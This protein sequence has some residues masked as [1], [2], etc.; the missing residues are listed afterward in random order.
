MDNTVVLLSSINRNLGFVLDTIMNKGSNTEKE[1]KIVSDLHGTGLKSPASAKA[2]AGTPEDAGGNSKT[3]KKL[4]EVSIS[5][6][7]RLL[8]ELPA[9]VKAV[10]KIKKSDIKKFEYSMT[11]LVEVL[12]DVTKKFDNKKAKTIKATADLL[13]AMHGIGD[14]MKD[15]AKLPLIAPF[16]KLGAK[17]VG[18]IINTL[19][20][21][22]TKVAQFKNPKKLNKTITALHRCVIDVILLATT[23]VIMVGALALVGLIVK[24]SWDNILIG[25][26][27]VAVVLVAL[28]GITFLVNLIAKRIKMSADDFAVVMV[29]AAFGVGLV[30]ACA[31]LGLIVSK[32]WLFVLL[33]FTGI[34]LTLFGITLVTWGVAMIAKNF[35]KFAIDV[36]MVLGMF[37]LAGLI[38]AMSALLGVLI[39][40]RWAEVIYGFA[41]I[42]STLSLIVGTAW[43]LAKT[44]ADPAIKTAA[45]NV[46]W[47]EGAIAGAGALLWYCM[48]LGNAV[49][50]YFKSPGEAS[51]KLAGT[52]GLITAIIYGAFGISKLAEKIAPEAK[53]GAISLLI[54]EGVIGC[55]IILTFALLLLTKAAKGKWLDIFETV[56][57]V[58]VILAY[59]AAI[60]IAASA[61]STQV[62]AGALA[63]LLAAAMMGAALLVTLGIIWIINLMS[64]SNIGWG[65]IFITLGAVSL[66]LIACAGIAVIAMTILAPVAVPA[67]AAL[68]VA[69]VMIGAALLV[70]L[71]LIGINALMMS[72]GLTWKDMVDSVFG[73]ADL[74]FCFGFVGTA[75]IAVIIPATLGLIGMVVLFPFAMSCLVVA[76]AT[77]IVTQKIQELGGIDALVKTVKDDLPKL[78]HAFSADNLRLGF[79]EIVDLLLLGAMYEVVGWLAGKIVNVT[80][81]IGK[82]AQVGGLITEDGRLRPVLGIDNDGKVT[83]GEPVDVKLI[84]STICSTVKVFV[85]N[86][87]YGFKDVVKMINAAK[88]FELVGKCVDPIDKFVKMITGYTSEEE[89][90]LSPVYIDKKGNLRNSNVKCNVREVAKLIVN[91]VSAFLDE[92]YSEQNLTKWIEYTQGRR[93]GDWMEPVRMFFGG[94]NTKTKAVEEIGNIL[95]VIVSPIS[96]FIELLCGLGKSKNGK[97]QQ[98]SIDK[99]GN[100]VYGVEVDA[101]EVSRLMVEGINAFI[102]TLYSEENIDAWM[103]LADGDNNYQA[104]IDNQMKSL[105]SFITSI[106]K[107]CDPKTIDVNKLETN[108]TALVKL[109]ADMG[110]AIGKFKVKQYNQFAS[111]MSASTLSLAAFDNILTKDANTRKQR[112]EELAKQLK[113]IAE[114]MRGTATSMK[115]FNEAL[116]TLQKMDTSAI[117]KNLKVVEQG[118]SQIRR[119]S[120]SAN[121]SVST[122]SDS[123][124]NLLYSS[125]K[126]ALDDAFDGAYVYGSCFNVDDNDKN[127]MSQKIKLFIDTT[128]GAIT[129]AN[130]GLT[131]INSAW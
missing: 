95:A 74:V 69:A 125:F 120:E 92:I 45:T 106:G 80:D 130:N 43:A 25:L 71:A 13:N 46:L 39:K 1:T 30:L 38:V 28:A 32:A 108:K 7:V 22:I 85:D 9:A 50:K 76:G 79:G 84:A 11:K 35:P 72:A 91:A 65:D 57:F 116:K 61:V 98:V 10:A 90:T 62:A 29:V 118:M 68:V 77:A 93:D 81:A 96:Q 117:S 124:N 86:C 23:G 14:I 87:N 2:A 34:A 75:A 99:D 36:Q 100:I 109:V 51:L 111:A 52:F 131:N 18:P 64:E 19:M 97:L 129:F 27:G 88:V 16:A 101:V 104:V 89:G 40:K 15:L 78:M 83:Y 70:T 122:V 12:A 37:L 103:K 31:L 59:C 53:K 5:E 33:G 6:I 26:V 3:K 112:L 49:K 73:L 44:A 126:R 107:L 21:G 110:S 58:S 4:K 105:N 119:S 128:G 94:S 82:L 56:F 121:S 8:N 113:S 48:K 63:L 115:N 20:K 60:A 41:A 123:S 114:T 17:M 24:S 66:I 127:N 47:V 54:I 102:T 67:T 42:A 55:A